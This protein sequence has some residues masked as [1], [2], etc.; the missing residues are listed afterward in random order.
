MTDKEF[1]RLTRSQLIDIIYQLQLKIDELTEQNRSLEKALQ[2]KRIRIDNAGNLAEAALEINN[3]FL[4]AQK[5][6]EQYLNEIKTMRD[7]AEAECQ[8]ILEEATAKSKG[9]AKDKNKTKA[10][11]DAVIEAL[12][13]EYGPS[14]G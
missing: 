14:Q 9:F 13:K 6:A 3:C 8:R 1:K 4:N 5:A 7:E 10:E 11:Y 2:D 12:L